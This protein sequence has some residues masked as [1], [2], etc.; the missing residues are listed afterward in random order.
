MSD[1]TWIAAV[2]AVLFSLNTAVA[3]PEDA[4]RPHGGMLRY[5]D[6]SEKH[7]VFV[8]ANDLWIVPREGGA[9]APL[10]SPPGQEVLPKFSADG[11]TIAFV[12]NYEGNR[13]LYTI[14]VDG[15]IS[16]RV[17]HHPASEQL[18]DWA[19]DGRLIFMTNGFAGLPRQQ[20]LFTVAAAGGLPEQMPVPYGANGAISAE[21]EWLAYTPHAIDF[22]TWKRYR[23]GMQTDVWLFNLKTSESKQMTDWEGLDSLPMWHGKSVYFLT[24]AGE[25]HRLNIWAYDTTTGDRR[26][27]TDLAD[28]DVKWPSI[29]PGPGGD[30]EIVF[31]YGSKLHLLDLASGKSKAIDVIIP[32]DRPKL[33][34]KKI[35]GDD[36]I[37][38]WDISPTGK[39]VIL[40]AR[41]DVW[42]VPAKEGSPRR[43]TR[44]SGVA[45]RDPSW[46]PDGKSIAYMSDATGE[47]ELYVRAADGKGEPR[48]LTHDSDCFRY[49]TGW[50]PDSKHLIF[51]D[52]TAEMHLC[53]AESG[54]TKLIDKGDWDDQLRPNWSPDSRWIAYSK[55]GDNLNG[56]IWIYSVESGEKHRVTAGVFNDSQPCFDRKGDFLYF[57]SNRDFSSP[58]YE[59]LGN[60][61]IY[62]DTQRLY[63][64][65]LRKDV[66]SPLAPKSDEENGEDDDKDGDDKDGDKDDDK[67]EDEKNGDEKKSD[68]A[69]TMS[70]ASDDESDD[71]DKEGDG[72]NKDKKKKEEIKPISIDL[73]GFESRAIQ[74]P[75]ERGDFGGLCVNEKG[76]LIYVRSPRRGSEDKPSI[77]ILDLKAEKDDDKKEKTVASDVRAFA[78]SA[79]G[80]KLLIRKDG[81]SFFIVD[82]TDDQKLEKPVPTAG[83]GADIDPRAEW[84]QIF[85]EAW[86]LHRDYFY[87]KNMHGVDWP[88]IRKQYEAMLTDCTSRDD[89]TYVIGEMISELNV[90]HAYVRGPGDVEKEPS[91]SVGMLACDF[92]SE[93][94][95]NVAAISEPPAEAGGRA[96]GAYRIKRI[97][98]GGAWD[99]DA[100]NPLQTPGNEVKEGEYLLAVNGTPLDSVKDPWAALQGLAGLNVTLTVSE[101]PTPDDK[102]RDVVVKTL[103][104]EI[105]QRYRAWIE[106]NRAYVAEKTGD[107]VGYIYVPNTGTDGQND[108][109]RQFQGQ[110]DKAAL[111][112][113]ER[114]NGG[115]QIPTRFIELLNRPVTN[116]WARR[117]GKDWMWPPDSQQ[118]PKCMLINGL[119]GSGGDMF[120][121][122]FRFN[123][124]GKLIGTRT[125]GGLVGISGNPQFIDGGNTNV[126]TFGFY[127]KDGSWGVEGHGV[128]PDIEVL[129]DPGKMTGG[130]DPQLDAAIAL[131]LDEIEKNPYAPAKRPADPDRRG[132]G[133][134]DEDR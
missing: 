44:S 63:C 86:R 57:A 105:P 69:A 17:T 1:R 133:L 96:G 25:S 41:G 54:E 20:Q 91:V 30:G 46:S 58:V 40:G 11:K 6:V 28:Y 19:P 127:E 93:P 87:V 21:G 14:D 55:T 76:R 131:M 66:K 16:R 60:S 112:I 104:G 15:G 99:A 53:N 118:G 67:D 32:G 24:D 8:Y 35:D 123:N 3:A 84:R 114:W 83:M 115:G 61:W 119:A 34:A 36:F 7:I 120:P 26:Q 18:C 39:R 124:L 50:S 42:T 68:D 107:R 64:V 2:A 38:S 102:A 128:D 56:A 98:C 29:G 103:E 100:R 71:E 89:V 108:L 113:D 62:S 73:D 116:Y 129:D 65:P 78:V 23:G 13:D 94:R 4:H 5:P 75:A 74:L 106:R 132:M 125:W 101:S 122:L 110:K 33:R 92:E 130:K 51:S 77:K 97:Y 126:P 37:M 43:L 52:K 80:E 59:D 117:D 49:L 95:T 9:A 10:A 79:D 45:E 72:D 22:R 12:G 70:K 82:A 90:G 81:E 121:W 88:A 85:T 111:I 48:Q 27:V 109:F 31:Q 47:Y 134:R